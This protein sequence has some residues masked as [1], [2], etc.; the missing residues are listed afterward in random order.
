MTSTIARPGIPIK[1]N[2]DVTVSVVPPA[3]LMS[4]PKIFFYITDDSP[5]F[6]SVMA[7][8][9]DG[10]GLAARMI[11]NPVLTRKDIGIS[12]KSP[13][14]EKYLAHYPTGFEMVDLI[15]ATDETKGAN[16]EFQT[17]LKRNRDMTTFGQE[18]SDAE[19]S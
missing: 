2:C 16:V 12:A 7:L 3:D 6:Q 11:T 14:H 18:A 19:P 9:E 10:T 15:D 1:I 4:L 17:A 8:A 5:G 13:L